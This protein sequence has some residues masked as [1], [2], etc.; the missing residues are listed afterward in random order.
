MGA[1]VVKICRA[2][3][4]CDETESRFGASTGCCLIVLT[5]RGVE[6][7]ELAIHFGRHPAALN[8]VL[9]HCWPS[10]AAH[11][12]FTVEMPISDFVFFVY[13]YFFK[14]SNPV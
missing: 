13:L 14:N 6:P 11:Q 10:G 9:Q 4:F 1:R 3:L 7:A 12:L 2:R 8:Q 5:P